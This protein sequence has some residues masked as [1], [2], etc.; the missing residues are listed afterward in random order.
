VLQVRGVSGYVEDITE[1][2]EAEEQLTQVTHELIECNQELWRFQR[3]L[4]R[5]EPLVALGR[6]TGTIA[7]ELGTP[8]NSVLG[9]T[10]LLFQET[11]PDGARE[12]LQMIETQTQRMIEIIQHYLSHTRRALPCHQPLDLNALIGETLV[13]LKPIFHQGRV[14]VRTA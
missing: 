6:V 10:Q 5:V 1:R 12:S 4:G 14:Q 13:L 7:H 3:E 8:L 11:L 9:Y 2:K